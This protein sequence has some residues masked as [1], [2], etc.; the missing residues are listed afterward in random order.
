MKKIIILLISLIVFSCVKDNCLK[1]VNKQKLR[2]TYKTSSAKAGSHDNMLTPFILDFF[3]PDDIKGTIHGCAKFDTIA[4][5]WTPK[6]W[7]A[8]NATDIIVNGTFSLSTINCIIDGNIIGLG[9]IN[10][11]GCNSTLVIRGEIDDRIIINTEEG[12]QVIFDIPLGD[13][14]KQSNK[15][16]VEVPCDFEIPQKRLENGVWW[17]YT[18][19]TY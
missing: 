5:V 16:E 15:F 9:T 19:L 8:F 10:I 11:K 3:N 6:T 18:D 1:I 13:S 17:E 2:A 14:P 12:G 7:V 4:E